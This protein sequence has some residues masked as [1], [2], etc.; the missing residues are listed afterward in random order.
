MRLPVHMV[1]HSISARWVTRVH[2][3]GPPHLDRQCEPP[4]GACDA[5]QRTSFGPTGVGF[6]GIAPPWVKP[7]GTERIGD[8]PGHAHDESF[9]FGWRA[10][11]VLES[12]RLLNAWPRKLA[13]LRKVQLSKRRFYPTVR[14][15]Q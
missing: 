3:R 10:A 15:W 9:L 13:L 7:T 12:V 5:R 1:N 4:G 2:H 8:G 11:L 14:V 6:T